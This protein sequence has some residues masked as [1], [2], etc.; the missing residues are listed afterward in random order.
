MKIFI[1]T[2]LLFLALSSNAQ[3]V[4]D[5]YYK[6]GN[7]FVY[8]GWNRSDYTTSDIHFEGNEYDFTLQNVIAKD[9]Q[10]PFN[11]KTYFSPTKLTIP[12]YN[13][14]LGYFFHDNYQIS[15]GADHMKYVMKQNETVKING[16]I[17]NSGTSYDGT[18]DNDDIQLTED[19]LKFEHTDG[20]NYENIEIRRFDVLFGLKNLSLSA[21]EGIGI[22]LLIPRTNTTLLNNARYD[23]FH[24]AGF[25]TGIVLA[26]NAT[27]FRHFFIQSEWKGGFINMPDIR[28]TMNKSDRADQHFWFSQ[29][30]IVF[31]ANFRFKTKNPKSE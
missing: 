7:F 12:Q 21:N 20:L 27:F 9:R 31:G 17:S 11:L 2:L 28:T 23:E 25:G 26:L 10:S 19:F 14:R 1:Y 3:R 4:T 22:G 6:K 29:Y 24:V 15:I 30:N 16:T 13:F 18:Y 8:W 5:N